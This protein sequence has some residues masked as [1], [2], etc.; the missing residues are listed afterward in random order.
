MSVSMTCF[1]FLAFKAIV[2][3]RY[4]TQHV[5]CTQRWT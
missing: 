1:V 2:Y 3:I 4:N 5:S